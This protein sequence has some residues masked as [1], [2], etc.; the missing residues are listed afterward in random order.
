MVLALI[1]AHP[2]AAPDVLGSLARSA[3][4]RPRTADYAAQAAAV[5]IRTALVR[6]PATR[7]ED[8]CALLA[9]DSDL[10]PAVLT[11]PGV[12]ATEA[13]TYLSHTVALTPQ[14]RTALVGVPDPGGDLSRYAL[15]QVGGA[16]IPQL[17]LRSTTA[18]GDVRVAAALILAA[19]GKH[20]Q[21]DRNDIVGVTHSEPGALGALRE[22]AGSASLREDLAVAAQEVAPGAARG[23][24]TPAWFAN[25][26]VPL[27][28][29][30]TYLDGAALPAWHRAL[31]WHPDPTGAL[32]QA[33]L[34]RFAG[35]ASVLNRLLDLTHP[36]HVRHGALAAIGRLGSPGGRARERRALPS[37][38]SAPPAA[39][40]AYAAGVTEWESAEAILARTDITPATL[41]ALSNRYVAEHPK[42][43]KIGLRQLHDGLLWGTALA[44]HPCA[45]DRQRAE[46]LEMV[47][48]DA[49]AGRFQGHVNA[50]RF[51]SQVSSALHL[52]ALGANLSGASPADV[53]RQIPCAVL[54]ES[55]LLALP[56]V[57]HLLAEALTA[58]PTAL[59]DEAAV[60][61]LGALAHTFTGTFGELLDTCATI[62]A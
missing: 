11:R 45:T 26:N 60:T 62:S 28:A 30:L 23:P 24:G 56:P 14:L 35:T 9:Q 52:G 6:N 41:D 50:D 59:T 55:T 33:A 21:Q 19:R 38:P 1:A 39:V 42:V 44:L 58:H 7:E 43:Y 31:D 53:G 27:D 57:R 20:T 5:R 22:A 8:V 37:L 48:E 2:H 34:D 51:T 4:S 61:I 32:G 25:R 47:E 49:D 12:T 17:V 3:L 46:G 36:E 10:L 15:A 29:L 18:P 13:V 16:R 54:R 40:E